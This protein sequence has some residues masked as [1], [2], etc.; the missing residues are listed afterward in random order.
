M[1]LDE[2][3]RQLQLAIAATLQEFRDGPASQPSFGNPCAFGERRQFSM[4]V[5]GEIH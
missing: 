2:I 3:Q 5:W 1:R 4:L